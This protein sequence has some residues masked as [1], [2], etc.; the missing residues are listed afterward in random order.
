MVIY[1]PVESNN[2]INCVPDYSKLVKYIVDNELLNI[3]DLKVKAIRTK[4]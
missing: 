4:K 1:E 2:K 3:D